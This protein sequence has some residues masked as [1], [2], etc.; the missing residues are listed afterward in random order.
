MRQQI[1]EEYESRRER[2]KNYLFDHM[3]KEMA[4]EMEEVRLG[5]KEIK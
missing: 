2:R 4:E 1:R 3:D 5:R